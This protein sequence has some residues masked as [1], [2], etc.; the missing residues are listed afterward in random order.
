MNKINSETR[1]FCIVC[2][3]QHANSFKTKHKL[4]ILLDDEIL[5]TRPATVLGNTV[6]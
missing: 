3:S 4:Q 5:V 6:F 2:G 1:P